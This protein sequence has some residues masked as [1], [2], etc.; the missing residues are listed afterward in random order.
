MKVSHTVEVI[1]VYTKTFLLPHS[2]FISKF[3]MGGTSSR[4]LPTKRLDGKTAIITG[5]NT[6]IGKVTAKELYKLGMLF[7][8][9]HI[10]NR[11]FYC[12]A[13]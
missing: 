9:G 1:L 8:F 10:I 11:F 7:F 3:N 12:D 2:N 13:I 5:S 6:G 4:V